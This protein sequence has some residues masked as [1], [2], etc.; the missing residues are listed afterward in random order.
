[1]GR[2]AIEFIHPGD[3]QVTVVAAG[4]SGRTGEAV[5]E[6]VNRF[7]T[8]AG[9]TR[10]LMWSVRGGPDGHIYGVAKDITA[11][12]EERAR[13]AEREEQLNQA[14]RLAR[15]GSW[16]TDIVS[17]E[18]TVSESLRAMLALDSLT[19]SFEDVFARVHPD[20]RAMVEA[21]FSGR[22]KEAAEFRAVLPDGSIKILSSHV[23]IA[24]GRTALVRGTVQDVTEPRS[25]ELALRRSEERF[26][27]GFDNAPIA[28][29][30]IDPGC[31]RYVRVNDAL[32]RFLGR[33]MDELL[34]MTIMDVS[35]PD[36]VE[37]DAKALQDLA[38]GATADYVCDKRYVRADGAI[39]WGASSMSTALEADGTVDVMFSQVLDITERKEREAEV[40]E[41]LAEVAWL[42][43]MPVSRWPIR[44]DSGRSEPA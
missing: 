38:S 41:Q 23:E 2:A 36:D 13:G 32:C 18:F 21:R 11:R 17:G 35:H 7:R 19:V 33:S 14:Q 8:K 37:S 40:R 31:G 6:V 3:R 5:A 16:S 39:V 27:Q 43:D 24:G 20:D 1:M 30:L 44:T 4:P 26:R 34:T 29:A 10:W 42:P 22:V 9:P 15:M 25:R 12:Y 28:V